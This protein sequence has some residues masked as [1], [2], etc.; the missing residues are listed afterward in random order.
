MSTN[1]SRI[2]KRILGEMGRA[3]HDFD[4]IAPGDKIM[5][6]V[7]GGKDSLGL[8]RLLRILKE[9]SPVHYSLIAVNLDQGQPGFSNASLKE[10]FEAEGVEYR[11]LHQDTYSIVKRLTPEGK[12]YC[13][14]CSRLRR[15][16]LYNAAV[17]LGCNKIAL[18][19][20]RE[21]L[22]ETL[23]LSAFFAGSLKSMPPK[24]VSDDG[25]NTVIRPLCYCPEAWM[26][27]YAQEQSFPIIPCNLCSSQENQQRKHI[28]KLVREMAE[29]HPAVPGNLLNALMN[30][31]PS[32]LL[33]KTLSS[34]RSAPPTERDACESAGA[35]GRLF[36]LAQGTKPRGS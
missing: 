30:V 13:P 21:D 15:G 29:G 11:L 6:A 26:A 4:L 25:R 17:E 14:V 5:V 2:E 8:L 32:H 16:I 28:K 9:R 7:S 23:L 10:F 22:I 20:H 3:I 19:H 1:T 33:D 18:G 35:E 34:T 12:T 27:E 31:I 24:L 36:A